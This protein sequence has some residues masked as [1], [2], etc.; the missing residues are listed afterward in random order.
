[1]H[2]ITKI[3]MISIALSLSL[4]LLVIFLMKN[5][6]NGIE[7]FSTAFL[8]AT[9]LIVAAAWGP[10]FLIKLVKSMVDPSEEQKLMRGREILKGKGA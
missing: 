5:V 7:L 8:P 10:P 2:R 6:L 1:M 9:L 4:Y 3:Q